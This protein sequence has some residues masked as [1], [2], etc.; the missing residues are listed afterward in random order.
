MTTLTLVATVLVPTSLPRKARGLQTLDHNEAQKN[1]SRA[2][3]TLTLSILQPCIV[4]G[5]MR[6]L[7]FH[8]HLYKGFLR[9]RC[10]WL[11]GAGGLRVVIRIFHRLACDLWD[12]L[13]F[14]SFFS[15]FP[16][17]SV[18]FFLILVVG[19][20]PALSGFLFTSSSLVWSV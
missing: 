7:I 8:T 15:L 2:I 5:D 16:F 11:E 12:V 17:I 14:W 13:H 4:A 3:I 19:A 18:Y 9:F 1:E 10:I 6:W 20:V